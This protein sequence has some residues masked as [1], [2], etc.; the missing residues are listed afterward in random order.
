MRSTNEHMNQAPKDHPRDSG[1]NYELLREIDSQGSSN[2]RELARR[3]GVSVGK[4]NYCLR[5]LVDK[6]WVKV[7]NFRRTDN[8]WAYAY[9]LTPSGMSAKMKL[10]RAF[11]QRKEHEFEQLQSEIA[12]LRR[13]VTQG[14]PG[15][16]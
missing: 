12:D 15:N 3:M 2:Q 13:E 7:N 9:L 14:S 4:I 11:L 6:G 16:E 1:L 8:K 5:A 10:A